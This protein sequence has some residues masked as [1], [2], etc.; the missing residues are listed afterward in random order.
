MLYIIMEISD[1]PLKEAEKALKYI[2]EQVKNFEVEKTF[3]WKDGFSIFWKDTPL[4]IKG[5]KISEEDKINLENKDYDK[6]PDAP[7][8]FIKKHLTLYKISPEEKNFYE[9]NNIL[10]FTTYQQFDLIKLI[11]NIPWIKPMK[12]LNDLSTRPVKNI[13]I[14]Y[15]PFIEDIYTSIKPQQ[16]NFTI[17]SFKNFYKQQNILVDFKDKINHLIKQEIFNEDII[18]SF[19]NEN[20]DLIHNSSI[21]HVIFIPLK[22]KY[23]NLPYYLI[24]YIISLEQRVI[25]KYK[26]NKLMGFYFI[27]DHKLKNINIENFS[28]V[29]DSRL[30]DLNISYKRDKKLVLFN[31]TYNNE[32]LFQLIYNLNDFFN[33]NLNKEILSFIIKN[34]KNDFN[35]TL[36]EEY[37]SLGGILSALV[38]KDTIENYNTDIEKAFWGISGNIKNNYGLLLYISEKIN[39]LIEIAKNNQLATSTKDPFATKDSVDKILKLLKQNNLNIPFNL[40]KEENLKEFFNKRLDI[41]KYNI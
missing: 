13:Y 8:N 6:L 23:K 4:I 7:N 5:P 35:T 16:K 9:E 39:F 38:Y 28:I 34:L 14:S 25:A 17:E 24:D 26:D 19:Y 12:I 27:I 30:E 36:V 41:K 33:F 29:I 10:Y 21:P 37:P 3:I 22:D 11:K 32:N 18:K 2:S 15:K 20:K 1:I 40:L 31:N